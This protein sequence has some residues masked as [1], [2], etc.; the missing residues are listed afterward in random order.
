MLNLN[1]LPKP[2]TVITIKHQAPQK[3]FVWSPQEFERVL[4]LS[5]SDA[6]QPAQWR[7]GFYVGLHNDVRELRS[8]DDNRKGKHFEG[9]PIHNETEDGELVIRALIW[10]NSDMVGMNYR[11]EWCDI[12]YIMELSRANIETAHEQNRLFRL[13]INAEMESA[14]GEVVAVAS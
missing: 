8:K 3:T 11:R 9:S 6:K 14:F 4:Y 7:T 10:D 1:V 2:Q 12:G 13:Q 5:K